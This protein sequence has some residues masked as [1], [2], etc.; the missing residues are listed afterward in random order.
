MIPVEECKKI[1]LESEEPYTDEEISQ[2]RDFLYQMSKIIIEDKRLEN[3][4]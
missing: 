3:E 1:L 4:E 2:I